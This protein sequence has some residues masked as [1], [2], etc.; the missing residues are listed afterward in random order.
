MIGHK[1]K[2]TFGVNLLLG[3]ALGAPEEM[4]SSIEKRD[5]INCPSANTVAWT[6]AYS[7]VSSI[8]QDGGGD[9]NSGQNNA[10][11]YNG[12][13]LTYCD[14]GHG[15]KLDWHTAGDIAWDILGTCWNQQQ[16][17]SNAK[18]AGRY[19]MYTGEAISGYV[20]ISNAKNPPACN[21]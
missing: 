1:L 8:R 20:C 18:E 21:C 11:G 9:L 3:L 6:S 7:M 2:V 13:F 19:T 4:K 17:D 15:K 5:V 10:Y 12:A 14:Y 16:Q